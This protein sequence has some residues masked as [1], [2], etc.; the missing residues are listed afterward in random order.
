M[1]PA[2]SSRIARAA[3]TM[4]ASGASVR[5]CSVIASR[6]FP[7][8]LDDPLLVG[9]LPCLPRGR[10]LQ[11]GYPRG[12]SAADVQERIRD[13]AL[14]LPEAYEDAPWGHPV[15][16][17]ADNKL[18]AMMSA[19]ARH[20]APDREADGRG[21]GDRA[22]APVRAQGELRRPLRLGHGRRHRRGDARRG[23]RVAARELLAQGA[24]GLREAAVARR[25]R[26][27]DPPARPGRRGG[28]PPLAE[29]AADGAARRRADDL[30]RRVRRRE[31]VGF[32]F[33]YELPR[34][35]GDPAML[36]VYEIEV[37]EAHRRQGI[38][39]RCGASSKVA[40]ERGIRRVRADGGDERGGDALYASVGGFRPT[41]SR[42]V[43]LRVV[44]GA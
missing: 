38:A 39:T 8:I 15:F 1:I 25:V 35:H 32:V 33:G 31:P 9:F 12:V 23:A 36:F 4:V 18:F 34:R 27:G 17:V 3:S 28:R 41:T 42:H 44:R 11:T 5:G 7:A 26:D 30:P 19:D 29:R 43:G 21:A 37:D 10:G 24:A 40:R 2:S 16:K 22:A 6:T 20:G 13:L 14:S